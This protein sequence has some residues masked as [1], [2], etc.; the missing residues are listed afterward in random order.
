METLRDIYKDATFVKA[1]KLLTNEY[2]VQRDADDESV[3]WVKGSAGSKY[4]VQVIDPGDEEDVIRLTPELEAQGIGY[5]CFVAGKRV[6]APTDSVPLVSCTCPN[7]MNRGGRPQCYHTL[8]V[9]LSIEENV[10]P[11]IM[12]S[13]DPLDENFVQDDEVAR[14]KAEGYTDTEIEFLRG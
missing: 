11:H 3:W 10:E 14:L 8:A 2:A 4:R 9:L 12:E 1:R 5:G 6:V 13:P 7:G